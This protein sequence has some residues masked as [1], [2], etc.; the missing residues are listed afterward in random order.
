MGPDCNDCKTGGLT[1]PGNPILVRAMI[2]AAL[3]GVSGYG[4]W[5]LLMALEQ[6]A[7]GRLKLVAVT[8]V[9]PEDES[10]IVR[11]MQRHGVEVYSCYEAMMAA[12]EGRVDLLLIPT[13]IQWHA[14]MTIR[15]LRAGAHVLV[16]KPVA[17]TLQ[18]IDEMIAVRNQAK[19]LIAVGFQDLYV[20][21][22]HDIKR[23]V[24][25][26]EVGQL[27]RIVIRA[28]WPRPISYYH[29]NGWAGKLRADESWVLDSPV[30]NA[31]A[32]FIM[33][34]L[35]WAGTEPE[36]AAEVT[37]VEAELGRAYPI[38]SFDTA[39]LRLRTAGGTEI[40]FYGSHAGSAE[41][42]PEVT[43]VGEAGGIAWSYDGSYW[44]SPAGQQPSSYPVPDQ[45]DARLSVLDA[46]VDR[47]RGDQAFV[48]E[49]ELARVH[50]R[51]FNALHEWFPIATVP[52][53]GLERRTLQGESYVMIRDLDATMRR[54]SAQGQLFS[55]AGAA[56]AVKSP[57][58]DLR[59][60]RRF[61]GCY[62]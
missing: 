29:R 23:R 3:V 42:A 27:R 13:G 1:E 7:A 19:R 33:L 40:L 8:I 2:R 34:A 11:R 31:F 60:Y 43:L 41:A 14:R 61:G 26:G 24:L 17:G 32:H 4:R 36:A 21:A 51:L 18:E 47:L 5:H 9:N 52:E 44:V 37:T 35:F 39:A 55:E 48:V 49:P 58:R 62:S 45:I 54:A 6:A 10:G 59:E 30:S 46:M 15:A 50:T 38:E 53:E 56:W 28:Q 22:A 25:S 16:E 20:S 12:C 57:P